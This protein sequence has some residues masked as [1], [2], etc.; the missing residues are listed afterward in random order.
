VPNHSWRHRFKDLCRDAGIEKAVAEA[1]MGHAARDV[2]DRYGS[3]YS[4][5]T[6]AQAIEKIPV[7]PL[8]PTGSSQDVQ[9]A[10]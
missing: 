10:A 6:L 9:A 1:L 4:L 5:K 3:G 7:P 8:G 2:G